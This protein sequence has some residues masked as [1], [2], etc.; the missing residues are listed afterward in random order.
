MRSKANVP[1]SGMVLSGALLLACAQV[2]L[3][4]PPVLNH[5]GGLLKL[6]NVRIETASASQVAEAARQAPGAGQ[7]GLRAFKDPQ[8]GELRSQTPEEMMEAA[9][10]KSAPMSGAA[11]STFLTP[12]GGIAAALD[13]TYMSNAIV[14]KDA[15]GKVRMQ[16]VTDTASASERILKGQAGKADRHDH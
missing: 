9:S 5:E 12:A 10:A 3:A 7:A 4:A 1:G 11:K 8:T 2:A 16:C 6:H 14:T 13:E 15:A